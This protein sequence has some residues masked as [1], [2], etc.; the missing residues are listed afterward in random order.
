MLPQNFIPT[1]PF[2]DFKWKWAC[3]QCTEGL[4]DPVILLGVLFRMRKLEPLGVKYSSNEFAK[5]LIDLSN[6]VKDS[7]GV[8]LERRTGDRNLIR[9]SGQYWRAVGLIPPADHS[10][11]I[12]LT[13]FGRKVA[14]HDISQTEFAAITIQTF[15]LPNSNIQSEEECRLWLQHDIVLHPLRLLLEI[16]MKLNE[17]GQGFITTEELV[18]IIIP[19]SGCKAE[20]QDYINFILWYRAGEISLIGWPNCCPE[21]ND[22][23][24][25]REYLLFLSNYGYIIHTSGTTRMEEKYSLNSVIADEICEIITEKPKDESLLNALQQIRATEV[26]AE[27]ER[28]RVQTS[29]TARPNQANFRKEVLKVC[30]RCIITNVMMPEVL[31]AAHIKPFKYNGE[32]TVANGFAMR[33]DIHTLFDTG[34]LRIS[35]DGVVELSSRARMD[36]GA[37]IPPRIV[38][39]DFTNREFLRWRWDNYNGM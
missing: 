38:V 12:K 5:E 32:D 34:H 31:E 35:E 27:V 19:L 29:R 23:R 4:N 39:P 1:K 3:L 33:T 37:S 6:D 14:D 10:G 26:I 17:L 13:E 28:K 24:I 7:I 21:S 22:M 25:A 11:Q 9:N 18:K 36:H 16:T 8:D 30:Q 20:L 15:K 2:E